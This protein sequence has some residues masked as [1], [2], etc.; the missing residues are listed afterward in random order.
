MYFVKSVIT[1]KTEVNIDQNLYSTFPA[2]SCN[3]ILHQTKS[4]LKKN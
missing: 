1:E 3:V 4:H 2:D